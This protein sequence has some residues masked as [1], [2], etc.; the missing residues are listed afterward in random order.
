[1][2]DDNVLTK[3]IAEQFLADKHSVDLE[4]FTAIEDEAAEILSKHD[5]RLNL[6]GLTSLSDEAA[7]ALLSGH[8]SDLKLDLNWFS[9]QN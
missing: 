3:E 9:L 2:S 5:D 7:R 4:E 6:T 1:M 8:R